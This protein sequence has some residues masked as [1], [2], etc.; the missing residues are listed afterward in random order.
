MDTSFI[1]KSISFAV[2]LGIIFILWTNWIRMVVKVTKSW[3]GRAVQGCIVIAGG[4][5]LWMLIGGAEVCYDNKI[6]L[7]IANQ[8]VLQGDYITAMEYYNKIEGWGD[9]GKRI[10]EIEIPYKY[11]V[12]CYNEQHKKYLIAAYEF[13]EI[14]DY[15]DSIEHL[16]YCLGKYLE[17][18]DKASYKIDKASVD[19]YPNKPCQC[20]EEPIDLEIKT[21]IKEGS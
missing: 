8:Y 15:E 3:H 7:T 11:Q 19:A 9:T 2:M 5:I 1:W 18:I 14:M 20:L 10:K 21:I 4:F 13:I 17:T 12:A 16:Y 6:T